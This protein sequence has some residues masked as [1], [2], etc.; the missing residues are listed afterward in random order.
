MLAVRMAI[1]IGAARTLALT[2]PCERDQGTSTVLP[3][4]AR[5]WIAV[6]AAAACARAKR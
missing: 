1:R 3:T 6:C 2:L 5:V 4:V